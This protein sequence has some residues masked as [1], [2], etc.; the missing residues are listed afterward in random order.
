MLQQEEG[1]VATAKVRREE[2]LFIAAKMGRQRRQWRKVS[3]TTVETWSLAEI[4]EARIGASREERCCGEGREFGEGRLGD[5]GVYSAGF[6]D[7]ELGFGRVRASCRAQRQMS[8]R[9]PRRGCGSRSERKAGQFRRQ[10]RLNECTDKHT[11]QD[12]NGPKRTSGARN[13]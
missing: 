1:V 7:G 8:R 5:N 11:I 9:T 12:N 6:D 10:T 13:L 2:E 3:F 4:Q